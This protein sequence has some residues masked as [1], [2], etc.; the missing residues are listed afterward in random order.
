MSLPGTKAVGFGLFLMIGIAGCGMVHHNVDCDR[1]SAQ[2]R[3]GANDQ[4][5][6]SST[7]Y[8]VDDVQSCSQTGTSGNRETANNYQDQPHL[9]VLPNI[10]GSIGGAAF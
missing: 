10:P 4:E 3:S 6:A 2:Q 7:G 5:V 1:I 9:P 8:S